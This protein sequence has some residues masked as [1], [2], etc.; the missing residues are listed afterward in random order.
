MAKFK[1][2]DRVRIAHP[3]WMQ[4]TKGME[5][6]ILEGPMEYWSPDGVRPDVYRI[7]VVGRIG[8]LLA[9]AEELEPLLPPASDAWAADA[10]RKVTKPL[11]VE[12]QAPKVTA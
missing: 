2:D 5:A 11:H 9:L 1:K 10:V 7:F 4:E 8:L 6:V 3:K 12:P